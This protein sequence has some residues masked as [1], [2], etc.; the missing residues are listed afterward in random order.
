VSPPLTRPEEAQQAREL[1][2]P[3]Y[4][5]FA[6]GFDTRSEGGEGVARSAGV[7]TARP[8]SA[9]IESGTPIAT[10]KAIN[11]ALQGG[12]SHSAFTWGVLDRLLEDER[13][14]Y[15]GITATSAGS[16]N[17]VLLADGLALGG[18]KAARELLR[19]FWEKMSDMICSSIMAPSFLDKMDPGF[20]LERSPGFL[21]V[22]FISRFM[23]PYQLNPS[24]KNPMRD[25]LNEVVDFERVRRQRLVKLFLS[26]TT[27]RTGKIAVFTAD[28]ITADHVLASA[29]VP[30]KM[31]APKIGSEHYWDGGFMGNPAI[32][33]VIYGCD[34]C[35]VLLVH[36]TPTERATLPTDSRA[37][38]NR[39][40]EI[41]FNSAL[42]REMRVIA[43]FTQMIDDG[44]MR[45]NKRMFFHL[46]D[47]EDIIGDLS[48]SSKMNA[49][50][51][52]LTYL[53]KIG[54]ERADKWLATNFDHLGVKS[55]VDLKSLYL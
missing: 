5:W 47:A 19:V 43:M 24:D 9:R 14:T 39:M 7:M 21:I 53:F 50:W 55:M 10:Q 46:I 2:A 54:R 34:S 41:C 51:K 18:R 25:L 23:S 28:E 3:V 49:D 30:F 36:L 37:I 26:A 45:G 52:F 22:D 11:L 27:V 15:D 35:D 32:F 6:E 13:L 4:G 33:P 20:G 17:A 29:C 40:E 16:V 44:K 1:L 8:K 42:M 48:G 31:R 12:G 38:L